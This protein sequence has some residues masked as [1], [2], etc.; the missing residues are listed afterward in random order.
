MA[1]ERRTKRELALE[2]EERSRKLKKEAIE[3]EK[4]LIHGL[5]ARNKIDDL[6]YDIKYLEE[7]EKEILK[8]TKAYRERPG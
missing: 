8:F 3:E 5:F 4:T 2:A 6:L 7:L 1:K